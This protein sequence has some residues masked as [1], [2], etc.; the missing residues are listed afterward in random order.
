[1]SCISVRAKAMRQY[2]NHEAKFS[3][4]QGANPFHKT[5]NPQGIIN[6]GTSENTLAFDLLKDKLEEKES[7]AILQEHTMYFP[8]VGLKS[9]R[10]TI[11]DFLNY[12]MKPVEPMVP[13][14]L[15]VSN[16]A[17]PLVDTL[18]YTIADEGEGLLIPSPFYGSFLLDLQTRSRVVP[19]PVELSSKPGPG[20]TKPF[21]LSEA[22]LELALKKATE[23]GI[24]IRGL[25]LCNPNNPLG[26]IYSEELLQSCLQFAARHSLHVIVDEIYMLCGFKEGCSVTNVL[27]LKNVPN[28]EMIH[29]LWGFSKDFGVSGFRCGVL[30]TSNKEV[31]GAI[32]T[33]YARF[34]DVPTPTQILL[35]NLIK[36]KGW[37]DNTFIPTNQQRLRNAHK[38]A[39]DAL[40]EVGIQVLPGECGLFM[41][42]DFRELAPTF[43]AEMQLYERVM[44]NGVFIFPG[45]YFKCPEPGWFRIVFAL[46]TETLQIGLRRIQ[47]TIKQV[48]ADIAANPTG[49]TPKTDHTGVPLAQNEVGACH[50]ASAGDESLE[51]LVRTLHQQIQGSDWLKE[52]TA[53]KWMADN[54]ELAKEFLKQNAQK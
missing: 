4:R 32:T 12:Y 31:Y 39:C 26:V 46:E 54:P 20:E 13:E 27:S 18:A 28:K 6:M 44:A 43:E 51:D 41:W 48:R 50:T 52:N 3:G 15:I 33:G 49:R 14:N 5:K 10:E 22:R 37:L 47:E 25:L 19:F 30:H 45:A 8:A 9:F 11:A 16:G 42:V 40:R 23:Q 35:E 24:K 36:D 17:T 34:H 1:M 53:E 2:F 38:M 29:V 7:H 21:E